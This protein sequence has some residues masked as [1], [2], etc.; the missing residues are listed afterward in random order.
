MRFA[1]LLLFSVFM[2]LFSFAATSEIKLFG[3]T[4][5]RKLQTQRRYESLSFISESFKNSVRGQG[6]TSLVQWQK[7]CKAMF[8]L[9]YIAWTEA[10]NFMVVENGKSGKLLYGKWIGPYGEGNV[11]CRVKE[12]D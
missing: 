4:E 11:Y 2:G 10:E 12:N 1:S 8:C 3:E 6:F 9:D 5:K 7:T